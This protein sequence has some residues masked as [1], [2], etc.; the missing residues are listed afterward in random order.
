MNFQFTNTQ[1]T[2][3][4]VALFLVVATIIGLYLQRRKTRTSRFSQSFWIGVRPRCPDH[5]TSKKAEAKLADREIRVK[6]MK[7][8]DLGDTERERF[9]AEWQIVQ[10]RFVDYPKPAV[11]EAG[12]LINAILQARG[13]PAAGFDQRAADLSVSYPRV[14]ENYRLANAVAVRPGRA[15]ASTE[16]L[17][18]AMVQYRTI[19]DELIQV[20]PP[21]EKVAAA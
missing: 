15:D 1:L 2:V 18:T 20:Q 9:V 21:N 12:D 3:A 11:I 10:G 7:I 17:R 8:R 6:F 14:M 4:V 19:F 13:Y 16:E 5:G